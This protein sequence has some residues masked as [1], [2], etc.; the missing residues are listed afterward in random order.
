MEFLISRLVRI[1]EQGSPFVDAF[2]L[3]SAVRVVFA[4]RLGRFFRGYKEGHA[5]GE[6]D[7]EH[8]TAWEAPTVGE[9]AARA[10]LSSCCCRSLSISFL[11]L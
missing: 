9:T 8:S 10:Y 6:D 3:S 2:K 1:Y 7:Q 4:G 11:V 5:P